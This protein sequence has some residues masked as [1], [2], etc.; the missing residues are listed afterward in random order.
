MKMKSIDKM[1]DNEFDDILDQIGQNDP[2]GITLSDFMETLWALRSK[3]ATNVIELTAKLVNDDLEIQAPE[4]VVARGN[5]VIIGKHRII[6]RW[7][8][9]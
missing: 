6:L 7:S 4:G 2:D 1:T 9:A 8:N 3:A 5:E